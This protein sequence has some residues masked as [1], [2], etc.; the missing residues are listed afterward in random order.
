MRRVLILFILIALLFYSGCNSTPVEQQVST[1]QT[2]NQAAIRTFSNEF[3]LENKSI[4]ELKDQ[5]FNYIT[6]EFN[7]IQGVIWN[8]ICF[9]DNDRFLYLVT[10]MDYTDPWVY[11]YNLKTNKA[12]K[13]YPSEGGFQNVFIQNSDSFSM[14]DSTALVSV[15]KNQVKNKTLFEDWKQKYKQ[16]ES[17]DVIANPRTGKVVLVDNHTKK[18]TLTDLN[19][20]KAVELPLTG[21]YSACWIDDNNIILGAFDH[22]KERQ[23]SAV[24]TYN[25]KNETTTKTYLGER[26][27]VGPSRDSDEYCGFAYLDD[28]RGPLNTFGVIDYTRNKIIFLDF[29]NTSDI[30][31]Q[32]HWVITATTEKPID[33]EAWE[34][35]TEG[36]VQL[37]VYDVAA[38][39]YIIR[40]KA[41]PRQAGMIISPDGRTIVYKTFEKN[42]INWEK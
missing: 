3:I 1:D 26:F 22:F 25:I 16:Y 28:D 32:S 17:C 9:L 42:Y 7:G 31:F 27:F 11:C 36:T 40:D 18:C 19:L 24:I 21:V 38:N 34:K 37:C 12:D 39:S 10:N 30:K 15:E 35:T 8:P 6:K 5:S 4:P 14:V 29:Q 2:V 23:G 13:L 33:W 41:L 20:Q